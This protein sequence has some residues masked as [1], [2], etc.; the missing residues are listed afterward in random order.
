MILFPNAKIN[1]GLFITQKRADGFHNIESL[2]LPVPWTDELEIVKSEKISFSSNGIE[3]D[4]DVAD[5]LCVK[6]YK[7]LQNEY[8][9]APVS[10][11]LTKN[12]PIGAGLG[13]GSSD[14]AF[15]L[16]GLNTLF[17]LEISENRLMNYAAQLGSDCAF[18]IP[19]KPVI[20]SGKGEIL[21]PVIDFKLN[22]YC[23]LVYPNLHIETKKAYASIQPKQAESSIVEIIKNDLSTWQEKLINDFEAPLLSIFPELNLLKNQLVDMGATFVSMSGSGSSFYAFFDE[24]PKSCLFSE[25][26]PYRIF[27]LAF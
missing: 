15:T 11:S 6:A 25:N 23:L 22:A 9:L 1:L 8:K 4:G 21:K 26:Y 7:L 13:G 19:N 5:N 2:F 14:A 18:F 16:K 10:I 20:A 24:K 12:I 17:N 27:K 3:I